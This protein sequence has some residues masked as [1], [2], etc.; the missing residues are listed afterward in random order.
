[1]RNL[2]SIW[3]V[4]LA[5]GTTVYGQ[6]DFIDKEMETYVS[7]K[8]FTHLSLS[9]GSNMLDGFL[10]KADFGDSEYKQLVGMIEGLGSMHLLT[11]EKDTKK[12]YK[13]VLAKVD[14]NQYKV[15]M[16]VKDKDDNVR[17]WS[18]EKK[19]K[20]EEILLLVG[21]EDDFVLLSFSASK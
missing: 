6:K 13:E 3:I 4:F 20:I 16:M 5:I 1:M 15:L 12:Y 21:G 7:H 8:D 10:K 17:V 14:Q 2:I 9:L 19:N 18:R 11:T